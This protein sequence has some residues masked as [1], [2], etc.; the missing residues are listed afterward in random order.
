M[1]EQELSIARMEG[2]MKAIR[3][4]FG[5]HTTQDMTQFTALSKSVA[6]LDGKLDQLLIREA[7]RD[8]EFAGIKRT[9]MV[10]SGTISILIAIA[11]VAVA[12]NV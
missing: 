7:R 1:S 11:G 6:T 3:E 9:A 10:L 8:G 12:L 4:L 2:E 5:L